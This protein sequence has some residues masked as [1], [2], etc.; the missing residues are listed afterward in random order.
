MAVLYELFKYLKRKVV[1]EG[2][3]LAT[4]EGDRALDD[5]LLKS[6]APSLI[7]VVTFGKHKGMKIEDVAKHHMDHLRWLWEQPG[8]KDPDL[9]FTLRHYLKIGR[10][11]NSK[12]PIYPEFREDIEHQP[13]SPT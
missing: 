9:M 1:D 6:C 11:E 12:E 7:D 13:A 10:N 4:A 3:V 5:Y 8:Q 2:T